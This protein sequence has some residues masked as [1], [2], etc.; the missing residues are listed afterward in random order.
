[1]IINETLL[2]VKDNSSIKLVK[3][4]KVLGGSKR[5]VAGLGEIIISSIKKRKYVNSLVNNKIYPS[6]IIGLKKKTRRKNGMYIKFDSNNA[7]VFS[8]KENSLLG[9]RIF[10]PVVYE[11]RKNKEKFLKILSLTR[12]VV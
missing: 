5:K 6:L 10:S 1:M 8:N 12:K 11:L 3:C 4:I 7:L 9:S 2:N